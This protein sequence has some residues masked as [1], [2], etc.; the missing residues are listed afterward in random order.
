MHL[1]GLHL[2]LDVGLS[3]DAVLARIANVFPDKPDIAPL[4]PVPASWDRTVQHMRGAETLEDHTRRALEWA[5][6]VWRAWT[7]H[8]DQVRAWAS[9]AALKR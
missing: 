3:S 2:A 1:V 8:H 4:H 9:R 7:P 6:G 5:H